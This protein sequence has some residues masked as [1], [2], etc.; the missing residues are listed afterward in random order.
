MPRPENPATG[1]D[2]ATLAPASGP[3]ESPWLRILG[4]SAAGG[5]AIA[6]LLAIAALLAAS[7]AAALS[8]LFGAALVMVFFGLSLLIGHFTG[9]TNPSGAL[10]LFAV[11]Y[12]IKVVGFAV[13]LFLFGT[14]DW[15]DR[16]WFFWGALATVLVWQVAEVVAFSRLRTPL[17][18]DTSGALARPSA[19]SRPEGH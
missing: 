16:T 8:V 7:P 17:Y 12:A 10:G 18:D 15:L 5:A 11:T 9:R 2:H 14:P 6:V 1:A 19:P 3:T 4:W 13:V